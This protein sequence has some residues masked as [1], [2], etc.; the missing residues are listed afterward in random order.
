[1]SNTIRK[2]V[3]SPERY[4]RRNKSFKAR[5]AERR[6]RKIEERIQYIVRYFSTMYQEA[7]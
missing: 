7:P 1:M 4:E 3:A 6:K 5:V 2:H